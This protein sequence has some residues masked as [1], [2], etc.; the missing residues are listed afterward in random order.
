M[1]ARNRQRPSWI[2]GRD[3]IKIL[4]GLYPR[5]PRTPQSSSMIRGAAKASWKLDRAAHP[6]HNRCTQCLSRFPPCGPGLPD[7]TPGHRVQDRQDTHRTDLLH[8]RSHPGTGR[9]RTTTGPQPGALEYREPPPLGPRC[10]VRRG[11][12]SGPKGP[13]PLGARLPAKR[14]HRPA[15]S[16][17]PSAAAIHRQ[18][19]P[20]FCGPSCAGACCLPALTRPA[21]VVI[22]ADGDRPGPGMANDHGELPFGGFLAG[23]ARLKNVIQSHSGRGS[24]IAAVMSSA[25]FAPICPRNS[26]L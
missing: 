22:G 25:F 21:Q 16:P 7:R 2:R 4:N 9:P 20:P 18:H 14:H 24:R 15:A 5:S 8:H 11:P 23:S 10:H 6:S 13:W 12:L 3:A 19:D 1:G 26:K 17:D